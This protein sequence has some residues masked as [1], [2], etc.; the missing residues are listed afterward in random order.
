[1]AMTHLQMLKEADDETV[2]VPS[3]TGRLSMHFDSTSSLLTVVWRDLEA[4]SPTLGR[5]NVTIV[6]TAVKQPG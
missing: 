4:A 5:L 1:M 2:P 6:V 3:R